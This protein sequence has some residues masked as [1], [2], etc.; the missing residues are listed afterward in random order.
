MLI[1]PE[2]VPEPMWYGGSWG[3]VE[4]LKDGELLVDLLDLKL[5]IRR[6]PLSAPV[7]A[8]VKRR[9]ARSFAPLLPYVVPTV[10]SS[11]S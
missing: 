2:A 4:T 5:L 3:C 8:G 1:G 11:L 9:G 10:L 7:K 6:F